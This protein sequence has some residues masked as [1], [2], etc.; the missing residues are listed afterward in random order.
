[1]NRLSKSLIC[2]SVAVGVTLS[3]D[4]IAAD[5][6]DLY[7]SGRRAYQ[8]EDYVAALKNLHAF[9]AINQKQVDRDLEFKAEVLDAINYSENWLRNA[10]QTTIHASLP[11]ESNCSERQILIRTSVEDARMILDSDLFKENAPELQ[12]EV[13]SNSNGDK[14]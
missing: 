11:N 10:L 1:M 4:S 14:Q 9:Y 2:L 13:E 8:N 7:D 3:H 12:I 5:R 6:S